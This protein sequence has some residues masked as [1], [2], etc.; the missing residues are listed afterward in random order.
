MGT[1]NNGV[2][3]HTAKGRSSD[4]NPSQVQNLDYPR[5]Q[6][7]HCKGKWVVEEGLT[8]DFELRRKKVVICLFMDM[9]QGKK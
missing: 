3:P 4:S 8:E 1:G 7:K 2:W 6:Y 9:S 5:E